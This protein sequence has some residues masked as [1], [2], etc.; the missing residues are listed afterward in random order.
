MYAVLKPL[1]PMLRRLAPNMFTTTE[2]LG[3]AMITVARGGYP[4]HILE[5]ADINRL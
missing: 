1:Y 2:R 5:M 3:R 4:R